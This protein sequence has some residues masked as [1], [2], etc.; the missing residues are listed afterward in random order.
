[1]IVHEDCVL[2]FKLERQAPV[3]ADADRPVT[4]ELAGEAMEPPP[5]SVHIFGPL[6][7]V[8]RE[9][10]YAQL[11]GMFRLN[12]SFRSCFEEFLQATVPEALDHSV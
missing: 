8:E 2:A 5:R 7:I 3:S 11:V 9:Q 6:G 4:F 12:A 1:M 10:L